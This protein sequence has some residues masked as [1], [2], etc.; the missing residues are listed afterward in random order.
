MNTSIK[1]LDD[2]KIVE[3]VAFLP[4]EIFLKNGTIR[5]NIELAVP[6]ADD[7]SIMHYA[8]IAVI[9]KEIENMLNGYDFELI[10]NSSNISQGQKQRIGLI[11]SLL[12]EKP[13]IFLDECFSSIDQHTASQIFKNIVSISNQTLI[14]TTHRIFPEI[15]DM[16]DKI[17]LLDKGRIVAFGSSEELRDNTLYKAIEKEGEN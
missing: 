8:N 2:D 7:K 17:Y 5:S 15:M 12:K 16:F 3:Y 14:M 6:N 11:I 9:D 1:D 13:Y 10:N 4:Q